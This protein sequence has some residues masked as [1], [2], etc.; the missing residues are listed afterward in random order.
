MS[1]LLISA[2]IIGLPSP[3]TSAYRAPHFAT[4]YTCPPYAT[5]GK[6]CESFHG[7]VLQTGEACLFVNAVQRQK[8]WG[9]LIGGEG[10]SLVVTQGPEPSEYRVEW[11]NETNAD[12][13]IHAFE[14][15][16]W[17]KCFTP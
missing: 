7:K 9:Y 16:A 10:L 1:L 17:Y 11:R 3:E 2:L 6:P 14:A 13:P 5:T 15:F 8:P 12:I 4:Y